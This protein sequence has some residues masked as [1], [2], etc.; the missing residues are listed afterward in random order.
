MYVTVNA[1]T[2]RGEED[3]PDIYAPSGDV[4]SYFQRRRQGPFAYCSPS[5]YQIS[6]AK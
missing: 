4:Y 6:R 2:F 1:I 5:V 3:N